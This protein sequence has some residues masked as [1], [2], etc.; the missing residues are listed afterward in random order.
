MARCGRVALPTRGWGDSSS[1]H[2][3]VSQ[4]ETNPDFWWVDPPTRRR[5]TNQYFGYSQRSSLTNSRHLWSGHRDDARRHKRA[6]EPTD[7][8][9][10][11]ARN[12]LARGFPPL[13]FPHSM[14]LTDEQAAALNARAERAVAEPPS[15]PPSSPPKSGT[16]WIDSHGVHHSRASGRGKKGDDAF[17]IAHADD[18]PVYALDRGD[19]NCDED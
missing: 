3:T 5:F 15:S 11:E 6:P 13:K 2:P 16:Q 7:A 8:T 1:Q 12:D 14:L 9:P 10:R 4:K 18:R 17:A 19:P